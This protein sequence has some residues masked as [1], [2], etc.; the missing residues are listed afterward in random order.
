MSQNKGSYS[1]SVK[2]IKISESYSTKSQ[3]A[4]KVIQHLYNKDIKDISRK[5]TAE[6]IVL[7]EEYKTI[8]NKTV[9]V[10]PL[11][12]Q[13]R[14]SILSIKKVKEEEK[15]LDKVKAEDLIPDWLRIDND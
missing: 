3:N 13:D 1:E 14:D 11:H 15:A 12:N 7:L 4:N 2:H 6:M 5:E 10:F 9:E 8:H